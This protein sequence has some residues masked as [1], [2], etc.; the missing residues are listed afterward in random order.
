MAF[1]ERNEQEASFRELFDASE[2]FQNDALAV[3]AK[4]VLVGQLTKHH[5]SAPAR[6]LWQAQEEL[7]AR[8][9]WRRRREGDRQSPQP[10]PRLGLG[11]P[12]ASYCRAL[13]PGPDVLSCDAG[14]EA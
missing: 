5:S 11:A 12:G 10:P 7:A 2:N 3:A 1:V 6:L 4:Y 9:S 8:R 14:E 13:A